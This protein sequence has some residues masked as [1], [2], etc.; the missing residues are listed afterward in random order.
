MKTK[1]HKTLVNLFAGVSLL[2]LATTVSAQQGAKGGGT[3]L[4]ELSSIKTQAEV[5]AL[6]PGDTIAMVCSKCKTVQIS[7]V[8]TESKDHVKLLR[9]GEKHT[10]PGCKST[11][12][13]VGHGKA[14]TDVVTH[15]C[16]S[17]GDASAFCCATKPGSGATKGM[18]K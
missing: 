3:K 6:K 7:Y 9:P 2:A 8:T 12:E 15:V 11:M 14:K 16:Q 10:C 18:A 1:F 13:V 4:L 5:E 17:C